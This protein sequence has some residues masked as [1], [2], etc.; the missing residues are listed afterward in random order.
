MIERDNV[1]PGSSFLS[2]SPQTIYF[3]SHEDW[4]Y[5]TRRFIR[6]PAAHSRD[7]KSYFCQFFRSCSRT[8]GLNRLPLKLV[9]FPSKVWERNPDKVIR[10]TLIWTRDFISCIKGHVTNW[11]VGCDL[12]AF[13]MKDT[14]DT[15]IDSDQSAFSPSR[16]M[17]RALS[18]T[19]CDHILS[20]NSFSILNT[21]LINFECAHMS[22]CITVCVT[23]FLR[24]ATW[25]LTST[26][27]SVKGTNWS[28]LLKSNLLVVDYCSLITIHCFRDSFWGE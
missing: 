3:Q 18:I 16:F 5:I 25:V 22:A 11:D 4:S 1:G 12:W 21:P 8:R 10:V 14:A 13:T 27:A 6:F 17:T 15:T 19:L 2:T 23:F 24:A 26:E 9:E 20:A 28:L 7:P